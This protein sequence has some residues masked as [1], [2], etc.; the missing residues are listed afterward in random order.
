MLGLRGR[1]TTQR[2]G[3]RRGVAIPTPLTATA[4][5]PVGTV[6]HQSLGVTFADLATRRYVV[7]DSASPFAVHATFDTLPLWYE[8][9]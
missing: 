5:R 7:V 9:S 4:G 3:M 1:S 8:G 6:Y 2:L